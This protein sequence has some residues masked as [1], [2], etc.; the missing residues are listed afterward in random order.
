MEVFGND[1]WFGNFHAKDYDLDLCSFEYDGTSDDEVFSVETEE[2]F[3]SD[4]PRASYQGQKYSTKLEGQITLMRSPSKHSKQSELILSEYDC[5]AIMRLVTGKRGYSWMKFVTET[6][7]ED[8]WYKARVNKVTLKRHNGEVM[9]IML[10]VSTDSYMGY[11]EEYRHIF[12]LQ[13]GQELLFYSTSDDLDN[14]LYPNV[15]LIPQATGDL[16]IVNKSDISTT[17][18]NGYSVRFGQLTQGEIIT[19]DGYHQIVQGTHLDEFNGHWIRFVPNENRLV[20]NM[21]CI[22]QLTYRLPR[23]VGFIC[24]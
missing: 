19:M 4:S 10:D 24:R 15:Q 5:R 23:K 11:S 18:P 17:Y 9:G 16:E 20:S 2:L 22:M 6:I 3:L 21:D 8:I 7:G 13:N 14:Y 1:F 12:T